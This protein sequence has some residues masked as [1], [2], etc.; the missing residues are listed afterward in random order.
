MRRNG[1][2]LAALCSVA[3]LALVKKSPGI[4]PAAAAFALPESD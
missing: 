1:G 3:V 2:V 4:F